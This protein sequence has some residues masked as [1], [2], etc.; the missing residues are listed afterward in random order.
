[1][2]TNLDQYRKPARLRRRAPHRTADGTIHLSVKPNA[3]ASHQV[4]TSQLVAD[5]ADRSTVF[6]FPLRRHAPARTGYSKGELASAAAMIQKL[7]AGDDVRADKVDAVR[8]SLAMNGYDEAM[9]ME[10]AVDR[11]LEDLA[12]GSQA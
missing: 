8:A 10:I 11:L 4:A 7:A 9:K 6:V 3:A 2:T 1:M 12:N 5:M